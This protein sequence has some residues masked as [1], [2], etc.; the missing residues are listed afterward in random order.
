MADFTKYAQ[1]LDCSVANFEQAMKNVDQEAV[2]DFLTA[3]HK[4]KHKLEYYLVAEIRPRTPYLRG[5]KLYTRLNE[6]TL[7]QSRKIVENFAKVEMNGVVYGSST[8]HNVDILERY[9]C[10]GP[11]QGEEDTREGGSY[12]YRAA[13]DEL[14]FLAEI[15]GSPKKFFEKS[16]WSSGASAP[17]ITF[18]A[19]EKEVKSLFN[20]E[21]DMDKI[22]NLLY[23]G[24]GFGLEAGRGDKWILSGIWCVEMQSL[25]L[26]NTTPIT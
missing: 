19:S 14:E 11:P 9:A 24:Y 10:D 3:L 18:R 7:P 12:A 13:Y 16:P 4:I 17:S 22:N 5:R 21:I 1:M 26:R 23:M 20:F 2:I 8:I 25:F 6:V 15:T